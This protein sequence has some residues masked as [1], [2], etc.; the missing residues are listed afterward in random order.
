MHTEP[1]WQVYHVTWPPGKQGGAF[2][3][4]L[5]QSWTKLRHKRYYFP[6]QKRL[7]PHRR[8][9]TNLGNKPRYDDQLLIY[10]MCAPS[11]TDGRMGM[12]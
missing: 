1:V 9:K 2:L 8:F 3:L 10:L 12:K 4:F 6:E 5:F 7:Y 11:G